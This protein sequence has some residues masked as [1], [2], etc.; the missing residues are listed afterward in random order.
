MLQTWSP[1]FRAKSSLW[2]AQANKKLKLKRT[3]SSRPSTI[4]LPLFS[5]L[6]PVTP[7]QFP[8]FSYDANTA[9]GANSIPSI[10]PPQFHLTT[11]RIQN[12]CLPIHFILPSWKTVTIIMIPKSSKL[13]KNLQSFRSIFLQCTTRKSMERIF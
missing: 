12:A 5:P 10:L 4:G 6:T 13:Q 7:L 3:L 11:N 8:T 1:N 2:S 9:T